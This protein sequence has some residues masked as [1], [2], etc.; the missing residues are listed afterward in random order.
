MAKLLNLDAIQPD[1]R[2]IVI[3]GVEHSLPE[4]T[5]QTFITTSKL[6]RKLAEEGAD[7]LAQI[8]ATI[9]MI[10]MCV[11]TLSAEDLRKLSLAQLGKIAAFIRG[12]DD[13]PAPAV[14]EGEQGK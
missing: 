10:A 3:N 2:S 6:A 11:G 13:E 4:M 14:Q 7:T 1:A 5:V 9:E 12:E 8:E